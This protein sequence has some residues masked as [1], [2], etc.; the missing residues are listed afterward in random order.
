MSSL[1]LE[2]EVRYKREIKSYVLRSR[3]TSRQRLA[4]EQFWPSFGVAFSRD[5]LDFNKLFGRP[6]ATILEIGFGMG[7][8]LL[9]LAMANPSINFLG[10]EVHKPG[11]GAL[12]AAINERKISNI[13]IICADALAVLQEVIP[14]NSLLGTLL[15]FPDPWPKRRHHKRRIVQHSFVSL[16]YQKLCPKGYLHLATD[17]KEYANYMSQIM[18][19]HPTLSIMDEQNFIAESL[20]R[21]KTKFELR[22]RELGN[23][24]TDLIFI[25]R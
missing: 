11:I 20:T 4:M 1:L 13:R 21:P 19:C 15:Y 23:T 8:S 9:R 25:K 5:L 14:D 3:M 24:I 10:V 17:V 7:T 22:G 2:N 6:A 12:L 16:V 18:K